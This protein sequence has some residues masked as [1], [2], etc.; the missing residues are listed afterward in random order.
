MPRPRALSRV[1]QVVQ[2]PDVGDPG[3]ECCARFVE[4]KGPR[5]RLADKQKAWLKLLARSG[6]PA[7]VC[8]VK[9]S[10]VDESRRVGRLIF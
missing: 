10:E 4:V 5:D 2:I 3:V 6:V 8:Q 1:Q 9:E 7:D